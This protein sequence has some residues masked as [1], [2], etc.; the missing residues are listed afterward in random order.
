MMGAVEGV[1]ILVETHPCSE[2]RIR[3]MLK[4]TPNKPYK[5]YSLTKQSELDTYF[6]FC[7]YICC[8]SPNTYLLTMI[9]SSSTLQPSKGP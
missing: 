1:L 4:T 7:E 3:E 5:K 6:T 8:E 9:D 2:S